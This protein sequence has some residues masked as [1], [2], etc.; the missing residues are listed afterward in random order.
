MPELDRLYYTLGIKTDELERG[1]EKAVGINSRLCIQLSN[2]L[3]EQVRKLFLRTGED[4]FH[5]VR[6][7]CFQN[8][9]KKIC[10]IS[11]LQNLY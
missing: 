7:T 6:L 5:V 10:Q 9:E 8:Q 3:F 1:I 4:P 2:Q 11:R